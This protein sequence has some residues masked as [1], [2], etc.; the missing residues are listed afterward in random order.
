[1]QGRQK[2][3]GGKFFFAD[4]ALTFLKQQYTD[5][6]SK[7]K[8]ALLEL[9]VLAAKTGEESKNKLGRLE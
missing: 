5:Q 1:M 9:N 7:T 3:I 8:N 6:L 4:E 2:G